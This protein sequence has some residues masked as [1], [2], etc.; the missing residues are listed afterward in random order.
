MTFTRLGLSGLVLLVLAVL[1]AGAEPVPDRATGIWSLGGCGSAALT[2][3]VN[4]TGALVIETEDTTSYVALAKAEWAAGS[5]VLTPEGADDMVLPPLTQFQRCNF[6]PPSMAV[7]FAEAIAVFKR[8]DEVEEACLGNATNV[9]RCIAVAFDVI[10]VTGDGLF[11][12][13]ELSRGLR[14]AGFFLGYHWA[15][16]KQRGAAGGAA[17]PRPHAFVPLENLYVGQFAGT[18][19]GPFIASNLIQ[20]YDFDGDG[21]LSLGEVMQDRIPETGLEGILANTALQLSPAAL[22]AFLK[23]LVAGFN[24]LP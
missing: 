2:V 1:P 23:S 17:A 18:A 16:D 10:D 12:Q 3:L 9:A 8:M 19:L 4:T 5:L 22:S 24:L 13:A 21:F 7:P 6:L 20:S 11:S 15:V 14:A